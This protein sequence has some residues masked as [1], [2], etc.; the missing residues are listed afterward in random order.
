MI[1]V[2]LET[3]W[4]VFCVRCLRIPKIGAVIQW[5]FGTYRRSKT[6]IESRIL[7]SHEKMRGTHIHY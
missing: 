6:E 4:G 2:L 7:K 1:S 3:V 5:D